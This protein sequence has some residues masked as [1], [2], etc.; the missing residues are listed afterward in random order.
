[1]SVLTTFIHFSQKPHRPKLWSIDSLYAIVGIIITFILT[2]GLVA[3]IVALEL[4][5]IPHRDFPGGP[6]AYISVITSAW[7]EVMGTTASTITYFIT[8]ALLVSPL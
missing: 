6:L 4:M 8:D 3:D 7:W 1:M 5:W 2:I